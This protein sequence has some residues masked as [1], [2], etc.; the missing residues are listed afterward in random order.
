MKQYILA[1]LIIVSLFACNQKGG[2]STNNT[3]ENQINNHKLVYETAHKNRDIYTSIVALNYLLAEDSNNM[4]YTDSL[5]RI[6]I[7]NEM[8]EPGMKLAKKVLDKNPK[9]YKL[10]E[11]YAMGQTYTNDLSGSYQSF[12]S[13]YEET[14]DAKYLYEMAKANINLGK[15]NDGLSQLD[16]IIGDQSITATIA[17]PT[18]DGGVQNV[19]VRAAALLLKAQWEASKQNY[20]GAQNFINKSLAV[21]PD[22]QAA[23]YLK[24]QLKAALNQSKTAPAP[25]QMQP[26][27]GNTP[28][29]GGFN[30]G[31]EEWKRRQGM[32]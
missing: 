4:D 32:K 27:V 29:T 18:A 5:A 7:L 14:K 21:A 3:G 19:N 23:L 30:E 8:L 16:Q 31:Y 26:S 13:L 20:N 25:R 22:F 1:C 10:K 24:E 9:N 15:T 6:Y 11:L 2:V 12:K 17:G 28:S